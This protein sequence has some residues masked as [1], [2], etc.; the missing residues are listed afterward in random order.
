MHEYARATTTAA[1][2]TE[3]RAGLAER[4]R[5]RGVDAAVIT[6]ARDLL[7]LI[8]YEG[9]TSLGPNPFA[10]ACSGALVLTAEGEA[11]LVVG[12]PDPWLIGLDAGAVEVRPFG[13]F[14]DLTPVR[15]RG[16]VG[17]ATAETLTALGVGAAATVGYEASSL[18][19]LAFEALQAGRAATRFADVENE[20]A[21]LRMRKS[22]SELA[23]LRRSIAVCDA[24]Q[25]AAGERAAA[26]VG[27]RDLLETIRETIERATGTPTPTLV[28]ASYGGRFGE[29]GAERP[30]R[31]GDLLVVD[32][33]PR[34]A[35]YWGDSCNTHAVGEVG[36]EARKMLKVIREALA[37]GTEAVRPGVTAE[38]VDALM[39]EH[40]GRD[41]P[42]YEG[43]GGHGIGVDFHEPP[44]MMPGEAIAL[45][46]DMVLALEP[47]IYLPH[48]CARL[49]HLVRVVP[50]G[51]EVLS[52][53]LA[54]PASAA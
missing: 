36:D 38:A 22:A 28:E 24:A 45:E 1:E 9:R 4:L 40:V 23:A 20:V 26:G 50:Q 13:T 18:P 42:A 46:S 25:A 21:L 41:F 27:Q 53:H 12:L 5:G 7:Y 54:G 19:V 33:A 47:G 49:E 15:A 52:R 32:I 39:R 14:G 29:E 43:S 16:R 11:V 6:D 35:G 44:R 34:V 10:G 8:G 17:A 2:Y 37:K 30:L 48:A 31:D 3:R 51:C